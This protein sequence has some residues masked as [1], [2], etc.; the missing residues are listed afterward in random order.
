MT[1]KTFIQD[2]NLPSHGRKTKAKN[3]GTI[4]V[5][6]LRGPGT[7][8]LMEPDVFDLYLN[9]NVA[10]KAYHATVEAEYL[11]GPWKE[12]KKHVIDVEIPSDILDEV[13]QMAQD[14]EFMDLKDKDIFPGV[15]MLDGRF[16]EISVQSDAGKC[17]L[18]GNALEDTLLSG[19]IP[20]KDKDFQTPFDRL[21]AIGFKTLGIKPEVEENEDN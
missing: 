18:C 6:I 19:I 2:I 16:I 4:R 13:V 17:S 10:A 11:T 21:A 15:L 14:K 3:A 7:C 12:W 20:T 1:T 8:M 5:H 9:I